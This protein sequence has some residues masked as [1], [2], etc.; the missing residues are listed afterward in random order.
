MIALEKSPNV[1]YNILNF[2]KGDD[3]INIGYRNVVHK[4]YLIC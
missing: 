4:K 3:L 1:I 2:D